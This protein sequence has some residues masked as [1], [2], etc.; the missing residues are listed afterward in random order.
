MGQVKEI[1]IK[2]SNILFFNN[3][4]N[5]RHF[6]SKLLTIDKKSYKDIDI[7]YM[8]YITIKKFDD[9][10]NINSVNTLYLIIHSATGH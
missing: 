5:I 6:H 10:E 3:I 8:G 4:I 1:S 2:K 7:Y 9:C